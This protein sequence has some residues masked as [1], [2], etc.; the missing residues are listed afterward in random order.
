MINVSFNLLFLVGGQF[1]KLGEAPLSSII[2]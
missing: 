2:L 1:I